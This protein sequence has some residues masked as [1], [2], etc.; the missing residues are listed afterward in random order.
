MSVAR[1]LAEF[2]TE[3]SI[4]DLPGPALEHAAMIVASTLASA[5]FG[6][7]IPSAQVM[8]GLA[9]EGGGRPE[10]SLWFDRG[11]KLPIT[12]VAR[13]NAVTSAAA[14]SD[15]SDL[16]NIV[17]AGTPLTAVTL[18]IAERTGASGNDVLAAI[19]CGYEASGR[20]GEAMT[21]S[22]GKPGHGGIGFVRG[23]HGCIAAAFAP[24]VS[25]GRLL[26]LS[27]G[28]LTH[29]IALTATSIGGLRVAAD[30]STAREYHD[31]MAALV[32]LQA[33]FAA[34]RGYLAEES[35]LDA[36]LGFFET[37]G[38]NSGP[39]AG[40]IAT[41]HLGESW[42]I[43]TDMAIKLV[44]G[45]HPY[46]A[47]GEAAASAVAKGGIKAH[48]IESITL[49]R[50]GM[51]VISGPR[52]PRD[53]IDMAHSP[54]YFAAA[55]AADADFSW[56]HAS[57]DKLEDPVINQLIDKVMIGPPPRTEQARYRQGATVTVRTHDGRTA[58]STVYEPRGS[59][60]L[61]I[62]WADVDAK[63][64]ALMPS[65]GLT[66]RNIDASLDLIHDFGELDDV[67]GTLMRLLGTADETSTAR[68]RTSE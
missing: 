68:A 8:R 51:E 43:L 37:F 63:Y 42:D 56:I 18:A 31:G 14:A 9:G 47:F 5:A 29:A 11:P 50:P 13:A 40:A 2:L 30:T 54:S 49:S 45:G 7:S 25:A 22:V 64:R 32:A 24:T 3:I 46:H 35:V 4:D 60:A 26:A 53:L 34:G 52:H 48:D 57:P 39:A 12:E 62:S 6:T 23:I 10:A 1:E 15:D 17:H 28:Q 16:R 55:G 66:L 21:P 67:V 59:A 27:A 36:P 65:S 61:G 20:I 33:V 41:A 58:A 44:P 19:V 38:H